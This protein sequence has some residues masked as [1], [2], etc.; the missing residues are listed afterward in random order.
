MAR[1][2][3]IIN[4]SLFMT[5]RRILSSIQNCTDGWWR[6][7]FFLF[8]IIF[9]W[10]IFTLTSFY[11]S[12]RDTL[13]IFSINSFKTHFSFWCSSHECVR[14]HAT[15]P[16]QTQKNTLSYICRR[17]LIFIIKDVFCTLVLLLQLERDLLLLDMISFLN[18]KNVKLQIPS[19]RSQS[20]LHVSC[21]KSVRWNH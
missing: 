5:T 16:L 19:A 3:K 4:T 7:Y 6:Q 10:H 9:D 2:A 17:P 15:A 11:L 14:F 12:Y 1:M 8:F 13:N 18:P 20:W 21:E